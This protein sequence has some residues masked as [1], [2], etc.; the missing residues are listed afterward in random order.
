MSLTNPKN[1]T[2]RDDP[3]AGQT[4]FEWFGSLFASPVGAEYYDEPT[5]QTS[6]FFEE[7][8]E[9]DDAVFGH[10]YPYSGQGMGGMGMGMGMGMGGMGGMHGR[11]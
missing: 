7:K 11:R 8:E 2:I 1:R 9:P 5:G 4:L 3:A 6:I 10:A